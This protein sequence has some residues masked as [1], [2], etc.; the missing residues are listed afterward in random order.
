M[1]YPLV[2][3]HHG[4]PAAGQS[5]IQ[6]DL[7]AALVVLLLRKQVFRVLGV[8]VEPFEDA[9]GF[10]G[11]IVPDEPTR[12]LGYKEDLRKGSSVR[13]RIALQRGM[14]VYSDDHDY[15]PDRAVNLAK[16][17]RKPS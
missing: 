8:G 13:Q 11:S 17:G 14:L 12:A 3:S 9:E 4:P 2:A 5:A 7:T 16:L 15:W 6:C 10:V 1:T